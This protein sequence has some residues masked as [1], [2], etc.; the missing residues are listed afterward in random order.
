MLTMILLFLWHNDL[1]DT[2]SIVNDIEEDSDFMVSA[3]TALL[4]YLDD[5]YY[6]GIEE[7]V[8][9]RFRKRW[10]I[11]SQIRVIK[12]RILSRSTCILIRIMSNGLFPGFRVGFIYSVSS[13]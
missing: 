11:I 6:Y 10:S 13:R 8:S 9:P 1:S 7:S 5:Y 2:Q 4:N 3:Y 12:Y